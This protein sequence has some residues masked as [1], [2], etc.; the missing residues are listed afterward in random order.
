MK[1]ANIALYVKFSFVL[2][3]DPLWLNGP[4]CRDGVFAKGYKGI[5]K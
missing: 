1:Q 3:C 4:D 5:C 2:L